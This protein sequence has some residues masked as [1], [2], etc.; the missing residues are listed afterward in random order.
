[1]AAMEANIR[2]LDAH[3]HD[4]VDS[5]R[6]AVVTQA[7]SS[8]AWSATSGGTYKQTVLIPNSMQFNAVSI[9]IRLST[10][11]VIYPTIEKVSA[12]Q[13]DIY[14]NDNSLNLTAVYSS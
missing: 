9:E 1:M 7:I 5:P 12:T 11:H 8:A 14:I 13:Y 10:G 6:L 4:G 3:S 2:Q